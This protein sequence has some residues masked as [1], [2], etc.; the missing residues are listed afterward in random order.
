LNDIDIIKAFKVHVRVFIHLSYFVTITKGLFQQRM[1]QYE[2]LVECLSATLAALSFYDNGDNRYLL[3]ESLERL[4]H[5]PRQDGLTVLINLQLYPALLVLYAAG[6]SALYA[7]RY[8]NLAAIMLEPRYRDYL[9]ASDTFA[10]EKLHV[11]SVFDENADKLVPR[12]NAEREYT[13]ANNHLFD[14]LRNGLRS[15]IPD[16]IKYE[17]A[18]DTFESLLALVHWDLVGQWHS[19]SPIGRFAWRYKGRYPEKSPIYDFLLMD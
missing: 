10:I 3:S 6:I 4:A 11:Y 12:D 5:K 17:G 16:D 14:V 1:R 2:S 18:F 15:Y 13:A 9:N 7:K 19:W 8:D